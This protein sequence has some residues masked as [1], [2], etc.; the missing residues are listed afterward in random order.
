MDRSADPDTDPD[1]HAYTTKCGHYFYRRFDN[2]NNDLVA[3]EPV[4]LAET[5]VVHSL[6]FDSEESLWSLTDLG[7]IHWDFGKG[8]DGRRDSV[9]MVL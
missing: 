3:I 8:R 7:L 4:E 6:V 9:P 2:E 5:G 1:D